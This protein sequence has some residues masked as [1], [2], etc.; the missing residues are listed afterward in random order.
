MVV[1]T[2]NALVLAKVETTYRT[3]PTPT[4]GANAIEAQDITITE[5]SPPLER[6]A[7]IGNLSRLP[8]ILGER[9]VDVS[10]KAIMFGSGSAGT[11]PRVGALLKGCALE[12][13]ITGG[14][15]VEYTPRSTGIESV[16]LW[17]YKGGRVHKVTGC[18]GS[19]KATCEA[20]Q[21][22]MYEFNFSGYRSAAPTVAAISTPT[23]DTTTA[24]CKNGTL[25]Y[26]S[27]TTLIGKMLDWDLANTLAKRA[28]LSDALAIQGFEITGRAPVASFNPETQ[29]ETSY[30]F[31]GDVLTNQRELSYTVGGLLTIT[32][33]KF[34]PFEPE[35]E[36]DNGMLRDKIAGEMAQNTGDDEISLLY[37]G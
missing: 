10:F 12:E 17:V 37:T 8:S 33:P 18:R 16:T 1:L 34:N 20:G 23:L 9:S 31:R 21:F 6:Q 35:L 36:D 27:K 13:T 25:S 29:V 22:M 28:D 2:R 30:D 32:M 14:T 15:S 4:V 19:V 24:V 5:Q 26:N 3:D 11:A 7:Q